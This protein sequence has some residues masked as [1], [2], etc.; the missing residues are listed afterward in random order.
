[1]SKTTK[2]LGIMQTIMLTGDNTATAKAIAT[3]AEIDEFYAELLPQ[4]KVTKVDELVNNYASVTM[5]GDGINDAPALATAN[6]G[7]AMAAIGNDIAIEIADIALMSDDIAKL[8]WLIKQ[9]NI[10]NN[11]TKY[12]LYYSYKSYFY[13]FSCV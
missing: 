1:M 4:D 3:Q 2:N 11:K 7:I 13:I 10:I 8:P 12:K 5:V 9:E 6:L